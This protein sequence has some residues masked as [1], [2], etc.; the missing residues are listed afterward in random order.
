M[1]FSVRFLLLLGLLSALFFGYS[2]HTFRHLRSVELASDRLQGNNLIKLEPLERVHFSKFQRTFANLMGIRISEMKQHLVI[3]G[4]QNLAMLSELA[5]LPNVD[6]LTISE[7]R[8]L[9]NLAFVTEKSNVSKI[10]LNA[11]RISSFQGIE[12]FDDLK[13]L[14]IRNCDGFSSFGELSLAKNISHLS[15]EC[16]FSPKQLVSAEGIGKLTNLQELEVYTD[17]STAARIFMEVG[18]LAQLQKLVLLGGRDI[19]DPKPLTELKKLKTLILRGVKFDPQTISS[20]I[21]LETLVLRSSTIGAEEDLRFLEPLKNLESLEISRFGNSFVRLNGVE[22]LSALHTF[23]LFPAS[24]VKDLTKLNQLVGLEKLDL[25]GLEVNSIPESTSLPRLKTLSLRE[26]PNLTN[27]HFLKQSK[28]LENIEI[29]NCGELEDVRFLSSCLGLKL[30]VSMG[31]PKADAELSKLPST[32][33][34]EVGPK[35]VRIKPPVFLTRFL[36]EYP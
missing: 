33:S 3:N 9:P 10:T 13:S 16:E 32:V 29:I 17:S 6:E 19:S 25:S 1:Q 21:S 18:S 36:D 28:A 30:V 4:D 7:C 8:A 35:V 24:D 14:T 22:S 5:D 12:Y 26:C 15:I 31:C 20:L 34:C 11:C 27:L 2:L 23:R